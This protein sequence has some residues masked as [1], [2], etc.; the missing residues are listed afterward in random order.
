MTV[1][2]TLCQK[3]NQKHNEYIWRTH[4]NALCRKEI[5]II[6][7]PARVKRQRGYLI[8]RIPN[9]GHPNLLDFI[10]TEGLMQG[11]LI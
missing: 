3:I 11:D 4:L 5:A 9:G 1:L 8:S 10:T 2:C 7:L 6:I